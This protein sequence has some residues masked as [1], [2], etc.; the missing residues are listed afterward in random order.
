MP[1]LKIGDTLAIFREL[2]NIPVQSDW[3]MMQVNITIILLEIDFS[4]ILESP[5]WPELDFDL[6]LF[7]ILVVNSVVTVLNEKD[8]IIFCLR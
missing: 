1:F 5:S 8:E 2:G 7:I 3:L 6:S 4:C